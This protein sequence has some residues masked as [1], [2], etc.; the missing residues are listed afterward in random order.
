MRMFD[1][2]AAVHYLQQAQRMADV[3][4]DPQIDKRLEEMC[5]ELSKNQEPAER[6]WNTINEGDELITKW[7]SFPSFSVPRPDAECLQLLRGVVGK[8]NILARRFGYE[9]LSKAYSRL[10]SVDT[11]EIEGVFKITAEV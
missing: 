1:E 3:G 11:N 2:Q 9:N 10:L 8:W 4:A 6:E 7:Q 5:L